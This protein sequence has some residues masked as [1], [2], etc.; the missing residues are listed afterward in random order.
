MSTLSF[1]LLA[2]IFLAPSEE[3][4]A[5]MTPD[6]L[7]WHQIDAKSARTFEVP[8]R[9]QLVVLVR[10]IAPKKGPEKI[11]VVVTQSGA[12]VWKTSLKQGRGSQLGSVTAGR[13]RRGT[14]K[15]MVEKGTMSVEAPDEGHGG[16]LIQVELVPDLG[17]TPADAVAARSEA[18]AS[19]LTDRP[20]VQPADG[21]NLNEPA[22]VKPGTPEPTSAP[23][24]VAK[25]ALPAAGTAVPKAKAA[26]TP[27]VAPEPV[28][29]PSANDVM[30]VAPGMGKKKP[31]FLSGVDGGLGL[32]QVVGGLMQNNASFRLGTDMRQE[33]LP[34][35]NLGIELRLAFLSAAG[36]AAIP[37]AGMVSTAGGQTSQS[38]DISGWS[39]PLLLRL[40][41]TSS[42]QLQTVLLIGP[43]FGGLSVTPGSRSAQTHSMTGLATIVRLQP[44]EGIAL[45]PTQL[46][47]GAEL[48]WQGLWADKVS[49]S[50]GFFGVDLGLPWSL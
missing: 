17:T 49:A 31:F 19:A 23:I 32:R 30:P 45:G 46:R 44:K 24:T 16:I 14:S 2:P 20:S 42:S 40:T 7:A 48:G 50:R 37:M 43:A 6:G 9:G 33:I 3:G 34:T 29:P 8:R 47:I 28:L 41:Q 38:V 27:G 1:I 39:M 25:A 12:T 11:K 21:M 18:G 10:R 4:P 35:I 5:V 15:S 26:A 13:A 22:L 36:N